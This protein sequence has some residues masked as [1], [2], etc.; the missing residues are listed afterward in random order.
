LFFGVLLANALTMAVIAAS[1]GVTAI[2]YA[3]S[4]KFGWSWFANRSAYS[5]T[6]LHVDG[7]LLLATSLGLLAILSFAMYRSQPVWIDQLTNWLNRSREFSIPVTVP[8]LVFGMSGWLVLGLMAI[9]TLEFAPQRVIE[10]TR[11]VILGLA[12]LAGAEFSESTMMR[13]QKMDVLAFFP[14]LACAGLFNCWATARCR[15]DATPA[16]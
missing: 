2:L 10:L 7:A 6:L 9:D 8:V 16:S 13:L 14:I 5:E 4:E 12:E 15:R 1:N 11:A 3:N